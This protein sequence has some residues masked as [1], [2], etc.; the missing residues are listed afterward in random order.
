MSEFLET[1]EIAKAVGA[2]ETVFALI[3]AAEHSDDSEYTSVAFIGAQNSGKTSVINSIVGKEL[4]EAS[5][6]S[7]DSEKPMRVAF[8]K[9]PS[10]DRFDCFDVYDQAW[11]GESAI[12]Y[13][14]KNTDA[15]IN[16][17]IQPIMYN[18][19]VAF[20]LISA[21]QAFTAED[22]RTINLLKDYNV[23][24]VLTKLDAIEEDSKEKVLQ[25]VT[26]MCEKLGLD[27]PIVFQKEQ[28][29]ENSRLFRDSLPTFSKLKE[30]RANRANGFMKKVKDLLERELKEKLRAIES[31]SVEAEKDGERFE[32]ENV[33]RKLEI[34]NR[35]LSSGISYSDS[36]AIPDNKA[37]ELSKKIYA[38]GQTNGFSESWANNIVKSTVELFLEECFGDT[39][40]KLIKKMQED[41]EKC[42]SD[43]D[44][45]TNPDVKP[46]IS[47]LSKTHP[48]YVNSNSVPENKNAKGVFDSDKAKTSIAITAAIV[49]GSII[50]PI[51]TWAT[52]AI[53]LCSVGACAGVITSENNKNKVLGWEESI[54]SYSKL[55][56][57]QFALSMKTYISESYD[58]F[59]DYVC[60]TIAFADNKE[61]E[62]KIS[63][64]KEEMLALIQKLN[65]DK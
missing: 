3:E 18:V 30:I 38:L 29:D 32:K 37:K 40:W 49:A 5:N 6:I 16:E 17:D 57:S 63:K 28:A 45:P 36:Y 23:K 22:V 24:I 46:K 39:K 64:E 7:D 55:V 60:S 10:D 59:A 62:T 9:M 1:R 51:P 14:I 20:Y 41:Y 58:K 19:D 56:L 2:K 12:L 65:A 61:K 50:V 43:F 34:K 33:S 35:L 27:S 31:D 44:I 52:V 21:L 42:I 26:G 15:F 48:T 8:E 47:E 53:S 13:E 4:R 54:Y 25:Y 11:N